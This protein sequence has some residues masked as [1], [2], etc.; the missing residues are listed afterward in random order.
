MPS[1]APRHALSL[2]TLLLVL[3]PAAGEE[4]ASAAA[5]APG[6]DPMIASAVTD[7][8]LPTSIPSGPKLLTPEQ[9]DEQ[10][11]E[12]NAVR[13]R[14]LA[15]DPEMIAAFRDEW[16]IEPV[17]VWMAAAGYMLDFRFNVIDAEKALPLFD[18]RIEPYLLVEGTRVRFGVPRAS[19]VGAFRPTNRGQNIEAGRR[20]YMLF[21]NPDNYAKRGQK[22]SIV[23]GDFRA[24]H[25]PI[26]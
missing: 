16:G 21:G 9:I 25:I 23:I 8:A 15:P 20:Y 11:A 18:H 22:V 6:G 14:L 4:D 19:K 12:A 2:L 1:A 24:E 3:Q 13:E 17:G 10:I 7:D 26:R 5:P